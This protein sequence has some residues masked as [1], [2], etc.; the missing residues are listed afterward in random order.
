MKRYY[1][2][3]CDE[4]DGTR[5]WDVVRRTALINN[6]NG[7]VVSSGHRTRRLAQDYC[8]EMNKTEE[9]A[10]IATSDCWEPDGSGPFPR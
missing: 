5:T 4:G 6:S 1:V 7:N 9:L 8:N 2:S 3:P 10:R